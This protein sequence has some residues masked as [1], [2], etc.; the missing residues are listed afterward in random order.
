MSE[1]L[2]GFDGTDGARD[3]LAFARRLAALTGARLRL[4]NAFPYDDM[5]NRASNGAFREALRADAESTLA[6]A[7]AGDAPRHAVAD[8]SPARALQ[9]IA[10]ET[11]A[12]LLVVGSTRRGPI[13][14]VVPGSTAERLLHGAPCPV[15]I[16]PQG[17][18]AP[19]RELKVIGVGYDGSEESEAALATATDVARRL[20]AT[21]RVIRVFDTAQIGTP[22][23]MSSVGYISVP[24]EMERAQREQFERRVAEQ[25]DDVEVESVFFAGVPNKELP[26]QSQSVD[27]MIMGSRGYGPVR[28][29]LLG[30]VS[31][32]LVREAACPV[33]VMP[34]GA[35]SGL[36]GLLAPATEATV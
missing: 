18:G 23:L 15:A 14:R 7:G 19:E 2:V 35:K 33:I 26:V 24:K 1:I 28:A 11:D 32:A 9:R 3:A 21:L 16:V 13:G 4:A 34:R 36:A 29:V 10:E 22:A 31:H 17:Y 6:R 25:P 27:L 8:V 30:G 20:G 5:P 12:S